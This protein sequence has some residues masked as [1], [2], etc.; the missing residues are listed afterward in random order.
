MSDR[1]GPPTGTEPAPLDPAGPRDTPVPAVDPEGLG[2]FDEERPSRSLSGRTRLAVD[3]VAALVA[4]FALYQVF[5]P[6]APGRQFSLI[7]FLAC[8]L[9]LVFVCYRSGLPS[10]RHPD[11]PDNPG[12]ADW[13][14]AA[15]ALAVSLYPLLP[16]P[17]GDGG[18]GFNAFLDRQGLLAGTDVIAGA[19]LLV[20][21]LEACRRTTGWAL[22]GACL[23]ALGYSYYGGFLPQNWSIAHQGLNLDEIINGLYNDAS[24]FYG[25]PLAVAASYIL[26]F[27]IYAAVLDLSGAGRFFIELSFAAFGR[28][29]TAPGR[30]V[31]LSGFLLGTVSGSG[32]ATTVSLGSVCWPILRRAGYPAENAGGVLAAAGV[33]AILS[34]PTLGA[35]AFIIA[36]YLRVSYLQVLLWAVLP[37]VLYY[38]GIVLAVEIDARRYGTR[39]VEMRTPPAWRLL[40]RYGYHLISLVVIVVF[41]ALDIPAFAAVVYAIGIQLVLSFL[42]RRNALTPTR[43]FH[44]LANGLRSVLAVAAVCAAAGVITSTITK[45]GL[46]LQMASILV[47]T[48]RAITEHPIGVLV[49]TSVLAA[50]AIAVLGLAVPV[51]ASFIIAWVIIAPS[52]TDLGV[53]APEA[54]M[55][56]F[57]F[58]VLSEVTPPTALAA[59]A[60]AAIT[61]GRVLPTMW[62][63]AKYTLPAFLVPFAFVLTDNGAALLTEGPAL[64]ILWTAVVAGLAVAA[65][66]VVTGGWMIDRAG[67]VERVLCLPAAL[68]LLYLAPATIAVGIALLAAALA[69]HLLLRSRD[70]RQPSRQPSR[71]PKEAL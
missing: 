9:P 58:A 68:L 46:G 1:E 62:Q 27:A 44:A 6:L 23:L 57:Y 31:A 28:S 49:V 69:V 7:L 3:T 19:V 21:V 32:A 10:R 65:L 24:G 53:A 37:T 59:V 26:L 56:I 34:P 70:R 2:G 36:E 67:P 20:L 45:T 41:L 18:G 25:V 4:A 35:A 55:F 30:T 47:G 61:G 48:A 50:L 33:G 63:T 42:D 43:L 66:A 8:V 54:A 13:V 64:T 71:Q 12:P 40:A 60:A 16:V 51:T 17:V 5:F 38:L 39:A 52:L 15:V 29:R 14:L 11:R 22:P